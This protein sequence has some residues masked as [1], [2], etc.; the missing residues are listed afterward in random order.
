MSKKTQTKMAINKLY[1][2]F[3]AKAQRR[4][5]FFSFQN[6]RGKQPVPIQISLLKKSPLA[7]LLNG[8]LAAPL[9]A[10]RLDCLLKIFG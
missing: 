4:Q 2:L 7:V 9:F 6:R 1:Q 10:H 3:F 8:R 5:P